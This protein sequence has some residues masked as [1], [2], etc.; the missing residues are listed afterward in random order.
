MDVLH[1]HT[2]IWLY[3]R[4]YIDIPH[5]HTYMYKYRDICIYIHRYT[6]LHSYMYPHTHRDALFTH[7]FFNIQT[8]A[9]LA[10]PPAL[11]PPPGS[12]PEHKSCG[13]ERPAWR[14]GRK[15]GGCAP[16]VRAAGA[17][18]CCEEE[19]EEAAGGRCRWR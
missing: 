3:L 19:E 16:E 2:Y 11:A 13:A 15:Y 1:M 17:A 5:I 18:A 14:C 7:K 9:P 12:P 4:T 8:H 6:L 10:P